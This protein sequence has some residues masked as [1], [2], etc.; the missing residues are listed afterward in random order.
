MR[1]LTL[2]LL[3]LRLDLLGSTFEG[4]A[5]MAC[6]IDDEERRWDGWVHWRDEAE[7]ICN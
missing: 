7:V 4:G 5:S 1:G 6:G 3:M 2:W